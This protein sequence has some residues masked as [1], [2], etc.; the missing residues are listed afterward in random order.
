MTSPFEGFKQINQ[1]VQ[2]FIKMGWGSERVTQ[3]GQATKQQY[4]DIEAYLD[5]KA[6]IDVPRK[7]SQTSIEQ[8]CREL[9]DKAV[10]DG[11]VTVA[12]GV[13]SPLDMSNGDVIAVANKLNSYFMPVDDAKE[14][15]DEDHTIDCDTDP[16]VPNRWSIEEHQK[17]GTFKFDPANVALHLD[18]GQKDGKMTEGHKLRKALA[19]Q[20]VLN[21]N[22]LDY[23]LANPHLISEEWKGKAV[24]FWGT[25]YRNRDG[26]LCVRY[27]FWRGD[28]WASD[29]YWLD[30]DWSGDDPAAVDAS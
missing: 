19:K 30:I 14:V 22:V 6:V 7:Y 12:E 27:L 10:K 15:K 20:P 24:F 3:L 1:L 26:H 9:L 18:K 21:A 4:R 8:M 17:G 2:K 5:G 23:L 16:Y 13:C 11:L 28:R 25:I 29:F